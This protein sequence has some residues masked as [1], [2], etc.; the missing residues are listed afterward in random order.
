MRGHRQEDGSGQSE[1]GREKVKKKLEKSPVL[2]GMVFVR[3]LYS[4]FFYELC[5][6]TNTTRGWEAKRFLS[7]CFL[8]G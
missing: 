8:A 2:C 6:G 4:C 5:S 1:T 3:G 7:F